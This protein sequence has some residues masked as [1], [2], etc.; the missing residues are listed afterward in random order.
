MRRVALALLCVLLSGCYTIRFKRGRLK[1]NT[2]EPPREH[3]HHS[4]FNG[5]WEPNGP[6]QVNDFCPGGAYLI[7]SKMG[8]LDVLAQ[9][10]T[11]GIIEGGAFALARQV[12][13]QEPL[14]Q[15]VIS[16]P[17]VYIGRQLTAWTPTSHRLYCAE[18]TVLRLK[19]AVIKLTAKGGLSQGVVDLFT[20]AL[21]GDLR[22]RPG[23]SV[24]SEADMTAILGLERQK[25]M[26]GCA[27][28]SCLAE[29]GGA[30]GVDR[31]ITGS[32]GRI[33]GTLVVNITSLDPKKVRAVASV[34]ERVKTDKDDAILEML[35]GFVSQ[36]LLE[37]AAPPPP[38][39]R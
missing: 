39:A 18:Q 25:Q 23:V 20:E 27:D 37:P 7:E 31:L 2:E 8:F 21:V 3:W 5:I 15:D 34:S 28:E 10:G 9:E 14:A 35:P 26:L 33:G 4:Y 1:A 22:K 38:P 13:Q 19:V 24:M 6:V 29:L 12:N 11:R 36:L 32:V 16:P 17:S 30:L